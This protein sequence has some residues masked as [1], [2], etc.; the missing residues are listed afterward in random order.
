MFNALDSRDNKMKRASLE[1]EKGDCYRCIGCNQSVSLKYCTD[2]RPH[3][4]HKTG[5]KA[6]AYY[7]KNEMSEWHK[8]WQNRFDKHDCCELEYYTYDDS[9][10]ETEKPK[11]RKADVM[12][13]ESNTVIEFQHS[14]M[15]GQEFYDRTKFYTDKGFNVVWV[16]HVYKHIPQQ[17]DRTGYL[18]WNWETPFDTFKRFKEI[19][20]NVFLYF[21]I[22]EYLYDV[23][24]EDNDFKGFSTSKYITKDN[25]E[26]MVISKKSKRIV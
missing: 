14:H 20:N 13:K 8:D 18:R 3:F 2:R 21:E 5:N 17:Y 1:L 16:F 22:D 15:D 10:T 12:I 9:A 7:N 23:V 25:F 19:K 4:A 6:C 24:Q 26:N 11:Y